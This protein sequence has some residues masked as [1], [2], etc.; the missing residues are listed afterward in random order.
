ML[1][2]V[3]WRCDDRFSKIQRL[4]F[5]SSWVLIFTSSF[6][7]KPVAAVPQIQLLLIV[8]VPYFRRAS[9]VRE[10]SWSTWSAVI[11]LTLLIVLYF[12]L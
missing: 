11:S 6:G 1:L 2:L 4:T 8:K 9:A 5:T 12:V 3:R 7:C 10:A